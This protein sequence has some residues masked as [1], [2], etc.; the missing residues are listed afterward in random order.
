MRPRRISDRH[1]P[2][3]NDE[4]CSVADSVPV[5]KKA[6]GDASFEFRFPF[7]FVRVVRAATAR[8][9]SKPGSA[10]QPI[11]AGPCQ[12]SVEPA[13]RA[14]AYTCDNRALIRSVR[15]GGSPILGPEKAQQPQS[16]AARKIYQVLRLCLCF[17][18]IRVRGVRKVAQN[19]GYAFEPCMESLDPIRVVVVGCPN[20]SNFWAAQL[21]QAQKEVFKFRIF[22]VRKPAAADQ[23]ECRAMSHCT[24]VIP[25]P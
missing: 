18:T 4:A 14:C 22:R 16:V 13:T 24:I 2:F 12:N 6:F 11:P 23:C 5:G 3:S 15:N 19:A 10:F 21:A 25:P 7:S 8:K 20:I 17:E 1:L 9:Q